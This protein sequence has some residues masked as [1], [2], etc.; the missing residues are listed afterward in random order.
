M[1]VSKHA[2]R[3]ELWPFKTLTLHSFRL[4]FKHIRCKF[5]LKMGTLWNK[6]FPLDTCN[7]IMVCLS[8]IDFLSGE[9]G[10]YCL[11]C[12]RRGTGN[13]SIPGWI[14]CVCVCV[15]VLKTHVTV[16]VGKKH[17]NARKECRSAYNF[18][19]ISPLLSSN[20]S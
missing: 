15:Y 9:R 1:S 13:D 12:K 11:S 10:S 19:H 6:W 16:I 8:L 3:S 4:H 17:R 2:R 14:C 18:S 20:I 7:D 5:Q